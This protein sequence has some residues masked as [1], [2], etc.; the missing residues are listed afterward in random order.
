MRIRLVPQLSE[1][2]RGVIARVIATSVLRVKGEGEC[3]HGDEGGGEDDL[4]SEG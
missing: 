3:C 4:E 1:D 2:V